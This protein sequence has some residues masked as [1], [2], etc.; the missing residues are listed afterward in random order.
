M[1]SQAKEH[2]RLP[3][4]GRHWGRIFPQRLQREPDPDNAL[5]V[6]LQPPELQNN[7]FLLFEAT[8]FGFTTPRKLM[9]HES[10]F[11]VRFA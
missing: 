11:I 7:K 4:A 6:D 5:I 8:Q 10:C 2:L 3:E 9:C 1:L